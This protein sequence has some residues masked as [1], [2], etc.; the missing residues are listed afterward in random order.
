MRS[1]ILISTLLIYFPP[2]C[3]IV[4]TASRAQRYSTLEFLHHF[5]GVPCTEVLNIGVPP[6][7]LR[8]PVHRG[9]Q[10]WS[11]PIH[12]STLL[13]YFPPSCSS[14]SPTSHAQRYS[15]LEF[16]HRFYGVPC[17]EVLNI[18]VPPSFLRRPVHRGTLPMRSPIHIST[19]LTYFPPLHHFY[20]VP[21][22]EV[23]NIGVPPSFL[24]RPVP[25]GTLPMR[26]PIHISTLL[27]YFPPFRSSHAQRYSTLEFLHHF[28]GVP[29][30]GVLNIGVP[31]SFLRR[32]VPRGTLPMRSSIRISTVLTYDIPTLLC[33]RFLRRLQ[34]RL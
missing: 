2:L 15:T 4:S 25:R 9:T 6:S 31:P 11:S 23:L 13:T 16:L 1:S 21:C 33:F 12:I 17:T 8:R 24:R 29:C 34:L 22:T 5:Y 30:T 26:S 10:H 19:L 27:T 18:G 14:H 7:F 28:Y 20:S 3:S 32:P